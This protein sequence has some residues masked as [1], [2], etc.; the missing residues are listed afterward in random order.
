MKQRTKKQNVIIDVYFD[1]NQNEYY[2]VKTII[3]NPP[4][5]CDSGVF[6]NEYDIDEYSDKWYVVRDYRDKR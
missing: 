6:L 1:E 4:D 5:N 3:G 2:K